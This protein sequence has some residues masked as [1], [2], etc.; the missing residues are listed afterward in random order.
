MCRNVPAAMASAYPDMLCQSADPSNAS[1][2]PIAGGEL[3]ARHGDERP[4]ARHARVA[5]QH[6][7]RE[8]FGDLVCDDRDGGDRPEPRRHQ[9]RG[10][11]RR[12]VGGV[13]KAV[14]GQKNRG[15]T[16]PTLAFTHAMPDRPLEQGHEHDR[17]Q[18]GPERRLDAQ[19]ADR[20]RED[21]QERRREEDPGGE[22]EESFPRPLDQPLRNQPGHQRGAAVQ[23]DRREGVDPGRRAD[24]VPHEIEMPSKP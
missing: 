7:V 5:Q 18:H 16:T 8:L 6:V 20:R 14:R 22:P 17:R 11:D 21:V 1:A 19:L 10:G 24:L 9:K 12:A 2:A 13:V 23:S 4:G 3:N 15:Q